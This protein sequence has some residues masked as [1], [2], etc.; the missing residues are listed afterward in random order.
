[1]DKWREYEKRK[2][3][4]RSRQARGEYLDWDAEI[5]KLVDELGL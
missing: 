3:L 2:S 4:L 1:M 5:Q